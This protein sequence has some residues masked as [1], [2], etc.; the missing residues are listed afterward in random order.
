MR[1]H[2]S[3]QTQCRANEDDF[4][5]IRIVA[6]FIFVVEVDQLWR[7]TPTWGTPMCR[8]IQTHKFPFAHQT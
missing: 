6:L 5:L 3:P 4:T 7:E 2:T 1:Q 8:E